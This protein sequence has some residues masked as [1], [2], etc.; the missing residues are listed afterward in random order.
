MN[1]DGQEIG[2][3]V[4]TKEQVDLFITV[5]NFNRASR[6]VAERIRRVAG[7]VGMAIQDSLT[8]LVA[9]EMG[10][11]LTVRGSVGE[12]ILVP[13]EP[14]INLKMA[15]GQLVTGLL[16]DRLRQATGPGLI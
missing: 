5:I 3:R 16:S 1:L 4:V 13:Y 10:E 7:S 11:T 8:L 14:E 9:Q 2:R 12:T 6:I 15:A